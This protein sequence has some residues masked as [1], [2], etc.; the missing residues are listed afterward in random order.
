MWRGRPAG[1]RRGVA[2]E[3]SSR[4]RSERRSGGSGGAGPPRGGLSGR[5]V[6]SALQPAWRH[7]ARTW[8]DRRLV[9]Q[10][11]RQREGGPG[12][13]RRCHRVRG[14]GPGGLRRSRDRAATPLS[15]GPRCSFISVPAAISGETT[16]GA[17]AI[18]TAASTTPMRSAPTNQPW[19]VEVPTPPG[20]P[21]SRAVVNR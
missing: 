7:R 13:F 17:S 15:M 20:A 8:R 4:C 2:G 11:V 1:P 6:S 16:S 19:G 12:V 9:P 18:T 21:T 14:S 10:G 3:A 5:S